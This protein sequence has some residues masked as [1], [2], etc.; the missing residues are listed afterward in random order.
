MTGYYFP[1][2]DKTVSML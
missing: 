2:K 1:N